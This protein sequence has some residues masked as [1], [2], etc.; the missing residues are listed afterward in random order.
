[1]HT[2]Y[3]PIIDAL[4]GLITALRAATSDGRTFMDAHGWNVPAVD[5]IDL[6]LMVQRTQELVKERAPDEELPAEAD[7]NVAEIV[8]RIALVQANSQ[9]IFNG[10]AQQAVPA[11]MLS[12]EG[13]R[14]GFSWRWP[15][16]ET[17]DPTSLPA[18]IARQSRSAKARIDQIISDISGLEEKAK[19]IESAHQTAENLPADLEDLKQLRANLIS[20]TGQSQADAAFIQEHRSEG[21]A[22]LDQIRSLS[23]EASALVANCEEAYRITTTKGLA[24]AFDQRAKF[25]N[26]SMWVWVAGLM[27]ALIAVALIGQN[28]VSALTQVLAGDPKW[29]TVTLNFL[30]SAISVGAPLWFAWVSTKQ[31]GQRF[32]L[33]EDYGFK[34]SVAKAYEGYRKEAARIDEDFEAKLFSIALTRLDEA[35]LRTVESGTP[36]SPWHELFSTAKSNPDLLEK[37]FAA[38]KEMNSEKSRGGPL[39]A[40]SPPSK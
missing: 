29:G 36:G 35:P 32:R 5:R 19:L 24:G 10:N 34:A 33:A 15:A 40:A 25:L 20:I 14:N 37:L 12:L 7:I 11:F 3:Q 18:K 6:V 21:S 9:Y 27:G 28:R 23:T 30:L 8:R 17:L 26:T 4:E 1:M 38:V 31:I 13:I 16:R 39:D 2:R 22:S